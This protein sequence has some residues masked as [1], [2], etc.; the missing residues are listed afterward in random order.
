AGLSRRPRDTAWEFGVDRDYRLWKRERNRAPRSGSPSEET[1]FSPLFFGY[2]ES[3]SF[4]A[5]ASDRVS[6][7]RSDPPLEIGGM[8]QIVLE[9][10]GRL[11]RLVVVPP[12]E[13]EPAPAEAAPQWASLFEAAG[14]NPANA[15]ETAPRWR[16]PVGADRRYA[17]LVASD[18]LAE[19]VRV[20]AASFAGR[21]VWFEAIAPWKRA[22][23][24]FSETLRATDRLFD[25]VF[26]LLALASLAVGGVL[27]VR[28]VRRGRGNRAGAWRVGIFVAVFSLISNA[29]QSDHFGAAGLETPVLFRL[30]GISTFLGGVIGVWYLAL[31]PYLRRRW[32]RTLISW[33][34]MLQHRWL[35]PLVGRDLL[36]GVLVGS[37]VRLVQFATLAA[38]AWLGWSAP[39]PADSTFL[40]LSGWRYTLSYAFWDPAFAVM[41][42][43][44][45]MVV[46]LVGHLVFRRRW[47][48]VAIV[49]A[50]IAIAL[51]FE[52]YPSLEWTARLV[53]AGGLVWAMV[54]YGLV[55]LT[56]ATLT[57]TCF[58]NFPIT[59]DPGVWYFDRSLLALAL[60]FGLAL[61]GFVRALGGH[62]L[63]GQPVLE[64]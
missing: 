15:R 26:I 33:N 61:F 62:A 51:P 27:A 52:N 34:R 41:L 40:E 5:A 29:F 10:D 38:P 17:W 59:L 9:P 18:A 31:E 25:L 24:P 16:P 45:W 32:P 56:A 19:P 11:R 3:P 39:I 53:F 60:I 64:D 12:E 7:F 35:D 43:L 2:R 63:F 54:R 1:I 37:S 4:M 50:T 23:Q 55:A 58:D 14:L 49:F 22:R 28:N 47:I 42:A 21:T 13:M 57:E 20:E 30:F 46:L 6:G 48:A 8:G 36:I 44:A